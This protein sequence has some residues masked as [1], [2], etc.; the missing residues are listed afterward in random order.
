M[1]LFGILMVILLVIAANSQKSMTDMTE[2]RK[3]IMI[4]D[5]ISLIKSEIDRVFIMGD[6]FSTNITIPDKIAGYDYE[7]SI[8]NDFLLVNMSGT[9]KGRKL[10][11]DN[12]TGSLAKG[13]NTITNN[14]GELVIS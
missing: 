8:T 3:N 1:I 10:M 12:I 7:I 14:D 5:E 2:E 13:K 4:D 6:G 11:T 9:L